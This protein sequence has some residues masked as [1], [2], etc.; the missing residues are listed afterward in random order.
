M[1]RSVEVIL[2]EAR[3]DIWVSTQRRWSDHVMAST[4][5]ILLALFSLV[6][7]L[8]LQLSRDG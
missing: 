5:P 4:T 8:T 7:I 1:C 6:T 2:E 3:A